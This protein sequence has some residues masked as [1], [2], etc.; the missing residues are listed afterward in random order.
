MCKL[1]SG[2]ISGI[3]T[4]YSENLK[5]MANTDIVNLHYQIGASKKVVL[6]QPFIVFPKNKTFCFIFTPNIP[7]PL[8]TI[9]LSQESYDYPLLYFFKKDSEN[10][11]IQEIKYREVFDSGD[12]KCFLNKKDELNN[13]EPFIFNKNEN[14]VGILLP[15]KPDE[16]LEEEY[17]KKFNKY[18]CVLIEDIIGMTFIELSK[19]KNKLLDAFT[20]E[21]ETKLKLP[22]QKQ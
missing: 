4:P 3:L 7:D 21:F 10:Y 16:F 12:L 19:T 14:I 1:P 6:R 13:I 9:E 20:S 18:K 17:Y 22:K 11:E 15:D 2:K 5:N 8:L